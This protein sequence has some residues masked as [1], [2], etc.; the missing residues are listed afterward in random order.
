M[1][2]VAD[3]ISE[4]VVSK[5]GAVMSPKAAVSI[6]ESAK[7]GDEADK[8]AIEICSVIHREENLVVPHSSVSKAV[9]DAIQ[10]SEIAEER[11]RRKLD[12]L[13]T[14]LNTKTYGKPLWPGANDRELLKA[15]SAYA[16]ATFHQEGLRAMSAKPI[17]HEDVCATCSRSNPHNISFLRYQ[18][19][20]ADVPR[21]ITQQM[22]ET[23]AVVANRLE[24]LD[25]A[26]KL[27]I[28]VVVHRGCCRVH[29][30]EERHSGDGVA[31]LP[32]VLMQADFGDDV[33]IEG[34]HE[35]RL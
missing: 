21:E 15:L 3:R 9:R 8:I 5:T 18:A 32:G 17:R 31:E 19:K 24:A 34:E 13:R 27:T 22:E 7:R 23:R 11:R 16:F 28:S 26:C 20:A 14:A 30:S 29:G 6:V 10:K 25:V 12:Q 35:V 1:K 33:V 4:L 2:R